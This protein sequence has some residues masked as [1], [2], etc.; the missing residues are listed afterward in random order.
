VDFAAEE[1]EE[2]AELVEVQEVDD[3]VL[4]V[5][6][7]EELEGVA[8]GY[9]DGKGVVAE[10]DVLAAAND[11]E[12]D[13]PGEHAEGDVLEVAKAA[14]KDLVDAQMA[15]QERGKDCHVVSAI[16]ESGEAF[17]S[18]YIVVADIRCN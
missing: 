7:V 9:G 2:A 13:A 4:I 11:A 14:P 3:G 8:L 1:E 16:D 5:S 18:V 12:P 6:G 15:G 10:F 17:D